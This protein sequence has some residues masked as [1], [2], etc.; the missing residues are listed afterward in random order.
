[1]RRGQVARKRAQTRGYPYIG[2][3]EG[4]R[5][6]I[7]NQLGG[8]KGRK[9]SRGAEGPERAG[10]VTDGSLNGRRSEAK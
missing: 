7:L 9:R 5:G 6:G 3:G 1:M 4:R 8:F 10:V 2:R